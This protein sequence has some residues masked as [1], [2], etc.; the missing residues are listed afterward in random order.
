ML[1]VFAVYRSIFKRFLDCFVRINVGPATG[2]DEKIIKRCPTDDKL[3][4]AA[5]ISSESRSGANHLH[6]IVRRQA[7][8]QA[9]HGLSLRLCFVALIGIDPRL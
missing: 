7:G 5:P 2:V 8:R 9:G 4:L 3:S 1:D 6:V